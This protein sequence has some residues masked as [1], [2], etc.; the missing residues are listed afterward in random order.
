MKTAIT[1]KKLALIGL[2]AALVFVSSYLSI[3]IPTALDNTRLHLGN[4]FCLLSGF[5]LGA[6]PGGLAAGIGSMFFDLLNPLYITSAPFTLVFKFLMAWVCGAIAYSGGR[7]GL[8]TKWN[9][10]A[11]V[12]GALTYV[13]LYLSKSFLSN[14]WFKRTEVETALIDVGMKAIASSTNAII[15]VVVAIPLAVVIRKAVK[16]L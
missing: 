16:T 11:G 12:T 9:I 6:L 4:V 13:V 14:V 1:T 7:Q 8:N 10:T 2:F 15:A 3:P 5:V